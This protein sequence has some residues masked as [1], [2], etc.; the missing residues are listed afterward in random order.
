MAVGLL[1]GCLIVAAAREKTN[2]PADGF[3]GEEI[4]FK[5]LLGIRAGGTM[6]N[7]SSTPTTAPFICCKLRFML[8]GFLGHNM[9]VCCLAWDSIAPR[10]LTMVLEVSPLDDQ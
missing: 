9:Y 6:A 1:M 10:F 7:S 4:D 5:T 3:K 2:P 8:S